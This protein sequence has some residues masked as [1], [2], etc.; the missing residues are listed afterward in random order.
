VNTLNGEVL[1]QS[2]C[3]IGFNVKD[4]RNYGYIQME[5][6]Q[7]HVVNK[8]RWGCFHSFKHELSYAMG[9]YFVGTLFKADQNPVVYILVNS[10]ADRAGIKIN[11]RIVEVN[12]NKIQRISD[13]PK[14]VK[15]GDNV[16]IKVEREGKISEFNI[17][18]PIIPFRPEEERKE[19]PK[20]KKIDL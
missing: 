7:T 5:E 19:K 10:I 8:L 4:P 2:G 13:Y 14:D 9:G 11:D 1:Y 18:I 12:G 3:S 17:K 20:D 15:Q 16:K 6:M